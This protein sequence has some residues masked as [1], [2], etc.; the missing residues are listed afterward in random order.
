VG[1][2]IRVA[3]SLHGPTLAA[4]VRGRLKIYVTG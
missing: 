3:Y 2:M 1:Q 4:P